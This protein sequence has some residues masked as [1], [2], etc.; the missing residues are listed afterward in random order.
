MFILA[1]AKGSILDVGFN[2]KDAE[3]MHSLVID[4]PT[5]GYRNGLRV[6]VYISDYG[7]IT[8]GLFDRD[9][10]N[11]NLVL[12]Q[13]LS[14]IDNFDTSKLEK[15]IKKLEYPSFNEIRD[16]YK[17]SDIQMI[18]V[19]GLSDED[20]LKK[21]TVGDLKTALIK[22]LMQNEY[23]SGIIQ[24]MDINE[25]DLKQPQDDIKHEEVPMPDFGKRVLWSTGTSGTISGVY[26]SP[27]RNSKTR[28]V[29]P[30]FGPENNNEISND[31]SSSAVPSIDLDNS[32]MDIMDFGEVL[33]EGSIGIATSEPTSKF[34]S[35]SEIQ[36]ELTELQK[37][38]FNKI[39]NTSY[40]IKDSSTTL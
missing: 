8:I 6:R 37:E 23:L 24:N 38:T 32:S 1:K 35:I 29:T 10:E 27:R 21:Y 20:L 34:K 39:Y 26:Q 31:P 25:N 3:K 13:K 16:M 4:M 22:A 28:T 15:I 40:L 12:G 9:I 7:G 5:G 14:E 30:G 11:G 19:N 36:Q 2:K 17:E 33:N 18:D